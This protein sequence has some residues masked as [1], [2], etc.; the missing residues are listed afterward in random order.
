MGYNKFVGLGLK[1]QSNTQHP[2]VF[3]KVQPTLFGKPKVITLPNVL[4][5][6]ALRAIRVPQ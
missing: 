1:L 4:Y 5:S 2:G 6:Q 3:P